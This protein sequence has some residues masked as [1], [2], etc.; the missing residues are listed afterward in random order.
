MLRIAICDDSQDDRLKLLGA[1]QSC[2][3]QLKAEG[4]Y[5]EFSSGQGLLSYMEKHTG[6]LDLVFLDMEMG[7]M[8]GMTTARRIRS[9]CAQV[10]LVFVTAYAE[11]VFEG[12][13]VS[14]LAYIMKPPS[15]SSCCKCWSAVCWLWT[16]RRTKSFS[17][18]AATSAIA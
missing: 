4:S 5:L 3:E 15:R 10:Q 7:A 9:S 2:M 12:Y 16:E 17:A 14:A 8:D 18:K 11:R 13:S 1:L 6:E